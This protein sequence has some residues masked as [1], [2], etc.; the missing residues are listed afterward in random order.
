MATSRTYRIRLIS[1]EEYLQRPRE[2]YQPRTL[3]TANS[4]RLAYLPVYPT[5]A[6]ITQEHLLLTNVSGKS[7]GFQSI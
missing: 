3:T 1:V 4:D 6:G 2:G 5:K 7:F